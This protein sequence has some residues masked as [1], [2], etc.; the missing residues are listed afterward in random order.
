MNFIRK[1]LRWIILIVVVLV[2][3]I[4]IFCDNC[5]QIEE[6]TFTGAERGPNI[7]I[8]GGTHGDEPSGSEALHNLKDNIE[9]GNVVIKRGTL[10]VVPDVN[11][12]GLKFGI[13]WNPG[14]ILNP[15]INRAYPSIQ[16]ENGKCHI[17]QKI[18]EIVD[19]SDFVLDLHEGYDFYH[20][21]PKSIGSTIS[22]GPTKLSEK[23]AENMKFTLN[24]KIPEK[25]KKFHVI[26]YSKK[27][28]INGTLSEYC[29]RINKDY[30]LIETT[31]QGDI[32]PLEI[33]V[34][35]MKGTIDTL[36]KNLKIV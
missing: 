1:N 33:R 17:S 3:L 15:D 16:G 14:N 6:F 18:K 13:R 4:Y 35:Q 31:G 32:Q 26:N 22:P 10:T 24:K 5:N 30:I 20:N 11:P 36:L 28:V 2:V 34:N 8:V 19:N 23:I 25:N 7:L 12:C 21:H 27:D 29:Q 9:N